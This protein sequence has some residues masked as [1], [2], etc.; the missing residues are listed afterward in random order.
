LANVQCENGYTM[1]ANEIFEQMAKVK[2][3]PTQYRL[4][5]VIWRYTYGFKR[6]EHDMSLA[7]LSNA[8]GCDKRQ[9]QRELK[10]LD[11]KNIINQKIKSGSFRKI[12]FNKN[13]ETWFTIGETT[14]GEIDNGEID[15]PTIGETVNAT[16]GE[17][18]NQERK[19]E[20]LKKNTYSQQFDDWW[21]EYP[22]KVEKKKAFSSF[23]TAL[24]NNS[25]DLLLDGLRGYVVYL[26]QS[27]TPE[28][29]IKHPTTFL[30]GE[31]FKDYLPEQKE[32]RKQVDKSL[33]DR[34]K[35]ID[36]LTDLMDQVEDEREFKALEEERNTLKREVTKAG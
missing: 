15:N 18:D 6:K 16:I 30:N 28:R 2:L 29:F 14:I 17:I 13:Y 25:Y 19:K 1:V 7:F 12:T 34:L 10:G 22:K 23:K 36:E 24:K 4:L 21:K 31:S 35:R 11:D 32:P 9:I 33:V 20:K 27:N 5:F 26:K 8:T 3:S